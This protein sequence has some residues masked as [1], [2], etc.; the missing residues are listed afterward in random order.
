MLYLTLLL[1]NQGFNLRANS[2]ATIEPNPD[3]NSN[4]ITNNFH[5]QLI[6]CTVTFSGSI[7]LS[8][9]S[10]AASIVTQK[11]KVC[12]TLKKKKIFRVSCA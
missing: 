3:L 4:I 2:P 7:A 6:L 12:H 5:T 8:I 9:C 1:V 10:I 11:A